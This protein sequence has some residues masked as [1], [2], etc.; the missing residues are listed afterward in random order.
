MLG[1]PKFASLKVKS[2]KAKVKGEVLGTR[3]RLA[4]ES[5]SF[6]SLAIAYLTEAPAPRSRL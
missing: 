3:L 6:R 5:E 1:A 4:S 2:Q